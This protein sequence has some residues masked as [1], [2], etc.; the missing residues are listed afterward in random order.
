MKNQ[1]SRFIEA[2]FILL[3]PFRVL[4][5]EVRIDR[6]GGLWPLTLAGMIA[7]VD[8]VLSVAD[9]VTS[10]PKHAGLI[11]KYGEIGCSTLSFLFLLYCCY[12][13]R[14]DQVEVSCGEDAEE[15]K[16]TPAQQQAPISYQ[17][18]PWIILLVCS[19]ILSLIGGIMN[20][21]KSNCDNSLGSIEKAAGA[22]ILV[23]KGLFP[24]AASLYDKEESIV[25]AYMRNPF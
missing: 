3:N 24:F 13:S 11:S 14:R 25:G 19:N 15:A 16:L 1:K 20:V 9:L 12:H 8:D 22:M 7:V 23:S 17:W 6:K 4:R 18:S 10:N 2:L 21:T 5:D